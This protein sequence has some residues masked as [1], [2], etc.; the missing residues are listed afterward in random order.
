MSYTIDKN[1][2]LYKA[3]EFNEKLRGGGESE[4]K[5]ESG[6][7]GNSGSENTKSNG[8]SSSNANSNSSNNGNS[9]NDE[10]LEKRKE[11]RKEFFRVIMKIL[12]AILYIFYLPLIPWI[13]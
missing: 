4:T 9:N 5:T 7:S 3:L 6:N 10:E 1:S 2:I 12:G 11:A 13:K 8:T